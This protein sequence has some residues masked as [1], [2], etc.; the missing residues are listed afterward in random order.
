[1][2]GKTAALDEPRATSPSRCRSRRTRP[3]R[4]GLALNHDG[5]RRTAFELLSYP[6][7]SASPTLRASGRGFG[8]LGA[9]DRRA[10]RDRRQIRGLS[11]PPG[12]RRRGL[13][14]RRKLRAAGRSRL[15]GAAGAVQRGEAEAR[16]ASAAHHRPGR[17]HRRHH[18][19][20]ADAAGRPCAARPR[21]AGEDRLSRSTVLDLSTDRRERALALT[22]VSRETLARL[23]R[24]VELLLQWQRQINLIAPVDHS[25]SLD[26][27]CRR[28]AAAPRRWRPTRASLGRSR[29]R[30]RISRRSRSPARSPS[31]PAAQWSIWLKATAKRPHSCAKSC[32][33]W[34]LPA[35][36]HHDARREIWGQLAGRADVVTA[37]ALAP[38]K[39]L[40]DQAFPLIER[41]ATGLFPKGQ[42]V[43]AELT[44]ATKYWKLSGL[45]SARVRPAPRAASSSYGPRALV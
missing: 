13:P 11:R 26:P 14:A 20:G 34:H 10:A 9:E 22:P 42:D 25:G 40:C 1:M 27:A 29:L 37:R 31:R 3:Q 19:G 28:F 30:R 6:T 32:G 8:E 5:Q 16:R 39:M 4:H 41:G 35:Q 18:A 7:I 23:D 44:E 38:L 2:T 33:R 15:R 21:Q 45:Q 12:R 43:E 17:P 24:F 36:V